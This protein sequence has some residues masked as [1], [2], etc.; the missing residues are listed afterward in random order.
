MADDDDFWDD[1]LAHVRQRVLVPITGPELSLV[2]LD[3]T[4]YTLTE[5]IARRLTER[6]RLDAP[7]ARM[8][9]GEAV[10][11]FLRKR[12][13]DE[14]ER[15]YRVISDI[16]LEFEDQPCAPLRD[17]AHIT[18]LRLFVS[19]TPDRLLATAVND[20][21]FH[22]RRIAREFTFSPN[23]STGDQARNLEAPS[24]ADTA[25]VRLFG[26]ATSM[27][28]YA[29]HDEDLLEWLHSL[30]SA[31]GYLP[32]WIAHALKHQPLLFI[33]CDLPDWLGRFFLR[34]SCHTRLSLE[35]K[36][37]F[38]VHSAATSEPLLSSFFSTYCRK[39]QVQQLEMAP[40]EFV[41]ELRRRWQMQQPSRKH[42]T[43]NVAAGARPADDA[44][45][46]ISYIREDID[47][48]RRLSDA[49]CELGGDVW[50]DERRMRPGDAWEDEILR[51][52]RRRVRLFVPI[53]S[54]NTEREDEGY[55]FR[56]W[57]EAVD[58]SYAIL[59]RRFIVPVVV[60]EGKEDLAMYRQIP[61]EFRRFNFGYAPV[62]KPDEG[63]RSLLVEEIR[64]MRRSGAA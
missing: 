27:P 47:E 31:T 33:G 8:T 45:I 56:E 38:F 59:R 55:V 6:Y 18:D 29:I 28:Q 5:L 34:L 58:R 48:A 2:T 13:R 62:G 52:I 37:F 50:L 43:T 3:N 7:P 11:A 1:L 54:S 14:T 12:G 53:I 61:D 32:E 51:A 9:M 36:Q 4:C 15:L 46:F 63:L 26:E 42:L 24:D 57:R 21:R 10:A 41:A 19:T 16:I 40:S 20:V 23:Q 49:I 17:L 25:I 39:S 30:L 60:D 64:A 22:G 44:T 35:S